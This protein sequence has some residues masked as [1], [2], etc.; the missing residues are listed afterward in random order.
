[1][2]SSY[3]SAECRATTAEQVQTHSEVLLSECSVVE[4]MS[5]IAS[6]ANI[7][8]AGLGQSGFWHFG[9]AE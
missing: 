5:E 6:S 4:A 7:F 3:I 1:M 2:E 9:V 8:L